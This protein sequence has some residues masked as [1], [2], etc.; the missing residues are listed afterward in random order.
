MCAR[1][2]TCQ[3][4]SADRLHINLI[5]CFYYLSCKSG[6]PSCPPG[7]G[8]RSPCTVS[9]CVNDKCCGFTCL[10]RDIAPA[11]TLASPGER[12]LESA[13]TVVSVFSGAQVTNFSH[14]PT[15]C[16]SSQPP[17]A[18]LPRA[19]KVRSR[20]GAQP[21]RTV[22]KVLRRLEEATPGPRKPNVEFWEA[23][24]ARRGAICAG[25]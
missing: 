16:S 13:W 18:T 3:I 6:A 14:P 21:G 15:P 24:G 11:F 17:A 5:L 22:H 2:I 10:R 12:H 8:A 23:T 1:V 25:R 19:R 20:T 9:R 4:Q 7:E